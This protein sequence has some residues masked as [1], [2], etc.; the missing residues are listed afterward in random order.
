LDQ[1]PFTRTLYE[2]EKSFISL[3][4]SQSSIE[5]HDAETIVVKRS[6]VVV[7]QGELVIWTTNKLAVAVSNWQKKRSS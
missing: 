4:H 5:N 3:L 6:K 2:N 1:G 7:W